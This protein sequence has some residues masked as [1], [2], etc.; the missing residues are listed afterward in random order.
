[1]ITVRCGQR[2][3]CADASSFLSESRGQSASAPESSRIAVNLVF[4]DEMGIRFTTDR[5]RRTTYAFKGSN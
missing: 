1:M 3:V 2:S 5:I 4:A